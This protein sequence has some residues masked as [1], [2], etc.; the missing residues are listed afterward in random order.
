MKAVVLALLVVGWAATLAGQAWLINGPVGQRGRAKRRQR[1]TGITQPPARDTGGFGVPADPVT[2][3]V[4]WAERH[5]LSSALSVAVG[6]AV[7]AGLVMLGFS[8]LG[9][10][11]HPGA[12]LGLVAI[13]VV[14]CLSLTAWRADN[15]HP[16]TARILATYAIAGVCVL[17]PLVQLVDAQAT[18]HSQGAGASGPHIDVASPAYQAG[19]Q[20]TTRHQQ[21]RQQP[22][23]VR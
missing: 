2:A 4:R 16:S 21:G 5:P 20:R 17:F 9:W 1:A 3:P 8:A 6:A 18:G 14:A 23:I 22:P 19:Y 15:R 10:S 11:V 7:G 13:V 12:T